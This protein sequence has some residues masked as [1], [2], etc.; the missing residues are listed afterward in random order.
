MSYLKANGARLH[1]QQLNP[2]G[3]ETVIL[4]HGLLI[5]SLAMWYFTLAPLLAKKYRVILYDLRG[6]G[7]S[8]KVR[9]GYDIPCMVRDLEAVIRHFQLQAVSLAGHS[10]G[11]LVALRYALDNPG[12]VKKLGIVEAPLPPSDMAEMGAFVNRSPQGMVQALPDGLRPLV[13]SGRRQ[14]RRVR[15]SLAFLAAETTLLADLQREPDMD[16]ALLGTLCLPVLLLYGE[17]SSC[18]PTG[19]RLAG[20]MG[21]SR[22]V[23][24][25]GGHYLPVERAGDVNYHL[26]EFFCGD[27]QG[28]CH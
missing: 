4:L 24:L 3:K 5:G 15:D 20:V 7:K 1:V 8:E 11:A 2:D 17:H 9:H 23:T 19:R 26:G 6:H 22:F 16:D 12:K 18:L 10:Y 27:D 25:P 13:L 28:Q 21:H 14:A